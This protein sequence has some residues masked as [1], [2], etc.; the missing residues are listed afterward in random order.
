MLFEVHPE[1]CMRSLTPFLRNI[2]ATVD[3]PFACPEVVK[4]GRACHSAR[5]Y[6]AIPDTVM[7]VDLRQSSMSRRPSDD[8]VC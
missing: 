4:G 1:Q 5:C 7:F 8:A 3:Q 2:Q 6:H